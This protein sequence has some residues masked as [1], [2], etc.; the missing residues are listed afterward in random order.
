MLFPAMLLKETGQRCT[1]GQPPAAAL[2][3]LVN[4]LPVL[5]RDLG[6]PAGVN[7]RPPARAHTR[8]GGA[9]MPA[10]DRK[11]AQL[12]PSPAFPRLCSS[13]AR[14]AKSTRRR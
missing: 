1:A 4:V 12:S 3:G 11:V 9:V 8:S 13:Y 14:R 2:H 7:R 10:T 6:D 5:V